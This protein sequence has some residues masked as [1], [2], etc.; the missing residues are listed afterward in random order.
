MS[1]S[2]QENVDN[3]SKALKKVRST[4]EHDLLKSLMEPDFHDDVDDF[5]EIEDLEL[6]DLILE[7]KKP[8]SKISKP[9]KLPLT[10]KG[11]SN[12]VTPDQSK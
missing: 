1:K 5:P 8:D 9:Y 6:K 4:A 10:K 12:I 3:K 11:K 7:G 2:N